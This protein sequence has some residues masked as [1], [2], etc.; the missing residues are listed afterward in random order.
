MFK[1]QQLARKTSTPRSLKMRAR[2]VKNRSVVH[3]QDRSLFHTT[4]H[5]GRP[6]QW[7]LTSG[8]LGCSSADSLPSSKCLLSCRME[9]SDCKSMAETQS[10][11]DNRRQ[12]HLS[13]LLWQKCR[14]M[15]LSSGIRVTFVRYNVI[16][17]MAPPKVTSLWTLLH[18]LVKS[19]LENFPKLI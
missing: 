19:T 17:Q 3:G 2:T 15:A 5:E 4:M 9:Q 6:R 13:T 7:V 12:R 10:F 18:N 11:I 16:R 8:P 14:W 1:H